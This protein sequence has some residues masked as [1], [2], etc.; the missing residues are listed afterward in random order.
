MNEWGPA[1]SLIPYACPY[2]SSRAIGSWSVM[3]RSIN[4]ANEV[5]RYEYGEKKKPGI[6]PIYSNRGL[7]VLSAAVVCDAAIDGPLLPLSLSQPVRDGLRRHPEP[8]VFDR[9]GVA[10]KETSQRAERRREE[11]GRLAQRIALGATARCEDGFSYGRKCVKRQLPPRHRRHKLVE[12][13]RCKADLVQPACLL[14]PQQRLANPSFAGRTWGV[15]LTVA[16]GE[17]GEVVAS[18][19][20]GSQDAVGCQPMRPD[21]LQLPLR[22]RRLKPSNL[23]ELHR[24]ALVLVVKVFRLACRRSQAHL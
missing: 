4:Y 13:V 6:I 5:R 12:L 11:A 7:E 8:E 3:I 9:F 10:T 2:I 23:L 21:G 22:L 16:L 24:A 17:A 18:A 1:Y 19:F 15:D 20:G 14:E